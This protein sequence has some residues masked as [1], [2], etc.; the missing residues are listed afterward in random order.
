M[1]IIGYACGAMNAANIAATDYQSKHRASDPRLNINLMN[2]MEMASRSCAENKAV[3]EK[4][5]QRVLEHLQ[6]FA[7]H[8]LEAKRKP[9]RCPKCSKLTSIYK[10]TDG[11]L[12]ESCPSFKCNFFTYLTP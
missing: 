10:T 7:P 4:H 1:S 2:V 11:T 3:K 5:S 8:K 9:G 6:R 12:A